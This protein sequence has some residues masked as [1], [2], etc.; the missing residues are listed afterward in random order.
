MPKP[1]D[2]KNPAVSGLRDLLNTNKVTLDVPS[3]H[4][5][6][7]LPSVPHPGGFRPDP[8]T[9]PMQSTGQAVHQLLRIAPD[10]RGRFS[11]VTTA[12]NLGTMIETDRA[13]MDTRNVDFSNMNGQFTYGDRAIWLRPKHL[14]DELAATSTEYPYNN[15]FEQV[16]GHEAGHAAGYGH[17]KELDSIQRYIKALQQVGQFPR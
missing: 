9:G 11:Q 15:N 3:G 2:Y 6:P 5:N 1:I 8:L 13:Q 4:D 10:L 7:D 14:Q 16:L 12:P 17:G